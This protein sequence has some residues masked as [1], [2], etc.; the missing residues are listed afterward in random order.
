[1]PWEKLLVDLG[2]MKPK[3]KKTAIFNFIGEIKV[4]SI[5]TSCGCTGA[6]WNEEAQRLLVKYTAIEIPIHIIQEGRNYALVTQSCTIK[7]IV[8]DNPKS[9]KL[10][11]KIKVQDVR[12]F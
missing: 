4:I 1:M 7:A 2:T 5:E 10:M 9:Y 8:N 6:D 11:I 3:E 12:I